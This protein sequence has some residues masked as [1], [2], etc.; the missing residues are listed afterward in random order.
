MAVAIFA[1]AVLLIC[2]F[3]HHIFPEQIWYISNFFVQC[4]I[5]Q[6]GTKRLNRPGTKT[7][8]SQHFFLVKRLFDSHFLENWSMLW[9][10]KTRQWLP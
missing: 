2:T 3:L 4:F 5:P 6:W 10:A 7:Q 8:D 9:S 1:P